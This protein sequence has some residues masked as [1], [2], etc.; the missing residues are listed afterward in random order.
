MASAAKWR[1]D[2]AGSLTTAGTSTAYTLTTN[3][4]FA[5]L[6]AMGGQVVSFIPHVTNGA[7]ATLN[8]DGLGA[9]ALT[10]DGST[11]LPASSMTASGI[12]S[13]KY[14]ASL[15]V[16]VMQN[17]YSANVLFPS[18]TLMLFQQTSAPTGWTKQT[19]HNDKALRVVSGA[20]SSGGSVAFTSVFNAAGGSTAISQANLPSYNLSLASLTATAAVTGRNTNVGE[21][22][23][24]RAS[25]GTGGQTTQNATVTFGGAI[26]LGGSGT[27]HTHVTPSIQYVDL[28][29]AAKD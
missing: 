1:D 7:A 8:V 10:V 21:T 17:L 19:T 14:D 3:Q 26:P 27:G 22:T 11:A 4:V 9:K 20:A 15:G 2:V 24:F 25:D 6:S 18:G 5:S 16:F 28:I 13:A 23:E 12:Y 29:I